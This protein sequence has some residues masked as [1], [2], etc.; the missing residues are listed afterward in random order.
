MLILAS[1]LLNDVKL[2]VKGVAKMFKVNNLK[3][4]FQQ[5][6]KEKQRVKQ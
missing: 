1:L 6:D 4:C 2:A 3:G 5:T